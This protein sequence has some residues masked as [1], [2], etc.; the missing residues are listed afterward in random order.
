MVSN[1]VPWIVFTDLDGT[2]LDHHSYSYQAALPAVRYLQAQHIPIVLTTSKTRAEVSQLQA[3]LQLNAPFIFEN[4]AGIYWPKSFAEMNA[5]QPEAEVLGV[6]EERGGWLFHLSQPRIHWLNL[7]EQLKPEFG[8]YFSH[9]AELGPHAIAELTGLHLAEAQRAD[10]RDYG[11]PIHWQGDEQL[12]QAFMRKAASL[13]AHFLMGGRFLHMSGCIDKGK[14][15]LWVAKH[16]QLQI[17]KPV[18]SLALGDSHNDIAMLSVADAAAVVRSPV[19]APPELQRSASQPTLITQ[20]MGPEGWCEAI[21]HFI[22]PHTIP[23]S[24]TTFSDHLIPK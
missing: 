3:A 11:E 20:A 4:G 14:A 18:Q 13:G 16:Y 6:D 24:Q 12:K 1:A 2:L 9:F 22:A 8:Q 7:L 21:N 10:Q 15:M 23:G 5:S 19:H 17:G